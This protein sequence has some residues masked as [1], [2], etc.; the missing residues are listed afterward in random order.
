MT[1]RRKLFMLVFGELIMILAASALVLMMVLP[2]LRINTEADEL[3]GLA[4]QVQRMRI[5][6]NLLFS[7]PIELQQAKL[8]T[9]KQE[10]SSLFD[11]IENQTMLKNINTKAEKSMKAILLLE[12]L[13][14][15]RWIL[16]D[17]LLTDVVADAE[18]TLFS[19]TV[20]LLQ[21]YKT[22]MIKRYEN[23]DEIMVRVGKLE[24][25]IDITDGALGS[26]EDV[27]R[28]QFRVI[29]T[30]I[31]KKVKSTIITGA[32]IFAIIIL[33]ILILATQLAGRMV[34]NIVHLEKGVAKLKDG[35]LSARFDSRSRDEIGKLGNNLNDFTSELS[36]S[37][38]KVK[39]ASG[40]NMKMKDELISAANDSTV[41]TSR[42]SDSV[43]EIREGIVELDEK[44][45][46]S[47]QEVNIVK[48]KTDELKIMLQD[49]MA[50]I[51]ES[52]SAV[53]E[54][55]ASIGSVGDITRKKKNATGELVNSAGIGGE[56]LNETIKIIQEIT[57]NV[58]EIRGTAS[59]IQ[60]VAA[61]T[62]LLAMNA[63]IEAA[64]AGKYGAGFAV[65]A[66]EIRKLSEASG[67]SSKR[68]SGVLKEVVLSIEKAASAGE[69]TRKA[70]LNINSEVTG[71]AE[72]LDEISGSME[73]LSAGGHQIL[74]AMSS[75]QGYAVRVKEGGGAMADSSLS[76]EEAFRIVE[77]VTTN[78]LSRVDGITRG[79]DEIVSAVKIVSGISSRLSLESEN[80]DAGI[81]K[82]SLDGDDEAAA[83]E[84][85]DV[86]PDE[87]IPSSTGDDAV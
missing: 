1:I 48:S 32:G 6:M 21:F 59:V 82:F 24:S 66:E 11:V 73:E 56:K 10:L 46:V 44:V 22:D 13:F 53:T 77:N 3:R 4:E 23:Y 38:L 41:S 7:S 52:T 19:G 86:T 70:F 35:K 87:P 36:S 74:E 31:D 67:E 80:I 58:D 15:E 60:S 55:I 34:R 20:P 2:V 17:K 84:P 54:M 9:E 25:M 33:F 69:D 18:A 29:R 71:V 75:L 45:A 37:I 40:N 64:H 78:V 72:A 16:L 63:A 26:A 83:G 42:I 43:V 81:A 61:Q 62:S 30:E 27:I 8:R 49:Q 47:G 51:E 5:E 14:E 65:V 12:E 85:E 50:M 57:S 79:V 76:L 39:E 68:I 28:T